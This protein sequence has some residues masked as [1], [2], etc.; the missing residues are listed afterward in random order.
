VYNHTVRERATV[1]TIGAS[2]KLGVRVEAAGLRIR[3]EAAG[4][5]RSLC[6]CVAFD[7]FF[8]VGKRD[9]REDQEPDPVVRYVALVSVSQR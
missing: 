4:L 5:R 2:L 8:K 3:V 7:E 6:A 9:D 1:S